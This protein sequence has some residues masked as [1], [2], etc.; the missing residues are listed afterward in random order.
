MTR[1]LSFIIDVCTIALLC[2]FIFVGYKNGIVKSVLS[3]VSTVLSFFI[4][5]KLAPI[6]TKF[7]YEKFVYHSLYNKFDSVVTNSCDN[8]IKLL[9][10]EII[11]VLPKF[12]VRSLDD[13]GIT[14][15]KIF[16]IISDSSQSITNNLM[17]VFQP[18]VIS[19]IKPIVVSVLFIILSVV[20]GALAK[21][22]NKVAK[23]PIIS[24]VNSLFGAMLG[25]VKFLAI[26]FLV[27]LVLRLAQPF[28]DDNGSVFSKDVIEDTFILSKIYH[29]SWYDAIFGLVDNYK[30]F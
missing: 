28:A 20:F 7:I 22:I 12:L 2:C 10:S 24:Q 23:F 17:N 11:N 4:S 1:D 9:P 30:P 18:V 26:L 5:G 14:D 29:N 15:K 19:F 27:G 16:D 3:L 25:F 6:V 8:G 21:N 13:Y